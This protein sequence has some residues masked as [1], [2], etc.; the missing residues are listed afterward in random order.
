MFDSKLVEHYYLS[1]THLDFQKHS[2]IGK[3]IKRKKVYRKLFLR[4]ISTATL[5]IQGLVGFF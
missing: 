4:H 3:D 2:L 1:N 5:E